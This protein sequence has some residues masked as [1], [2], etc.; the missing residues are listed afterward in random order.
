MP[1]DLR[2][3]LEEHL[4]CNLRQSGSSPSS[5]F[6][7]RQDTDRGR[8]YG[9]RLPV[10]GGRSTCIKVQS[11]LVVIVVTSA[12][13]IPFGS[14]NGAFTCGF[15]YVQPHVFDYAADVRTEHHWHLVRRHGPVRTNTAKRYRSIFSRKRNGGSRSKLERKLGAGLHHVRNK[16][17]V[18]LRRGLNRSTV[19][20][21]R[22]ILHQDL[23]S[24]INRDEGGWTVLEVPNSSLDLLASK[25]TEADLTQFAEITDGAESPL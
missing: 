14:K 21:S 22:H 13:P 1:R 6:D 2:R 10:G 11:C 12:P 16:V 25:R 4:Q 8:L 18:N 19:H 3:R 15:A 9:C 17:H 5:K 20:A 23:M 24:G 7:A